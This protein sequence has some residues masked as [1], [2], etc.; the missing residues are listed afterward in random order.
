VQYSSSSDFLA[1][2]KPFRY[3]IQ[4][5]VPAIC[6]IYLAW[7]FG[8]FDTTN[9]VAWPALITLTMAML[10]VRFDIQKLAKSKRYRFTVFSDLL[11]RTL[12]LFILS[13]VVFAIDGM[14]A[15]RWLQLLWFSSAL[16][17]AA[18][19]LTVM[20]IEISLLPKFR[21]KPIKLAIAAITS[22]SVAFARGLS[23]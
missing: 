9:V 11:S 12:V 4:L 23:D 1:I 8:W 5:G 13:V 20:L 2:R 6:S 15:A 3:L 14:L 19:V 21:R 7:V 10:W 22:A 16:W 17:M 18:S